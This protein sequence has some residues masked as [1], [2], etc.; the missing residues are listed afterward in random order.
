VIYGQR[1]SSAGHVTM[2]VCNLSGAAMAALS[3]FPIRTVT[4]R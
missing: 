1:A 3:N 4:F 2:V